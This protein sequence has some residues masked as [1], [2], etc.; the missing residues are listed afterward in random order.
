MVT[1]AIDV[2]LNET[3]KFPPSP[4]FIAQANVKGAA[5]YDKLWE[6]TAPDLHCRESPAFG[7][8]AAN[9]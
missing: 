9:S 1:G 2:V 5:E 4:E 3:R 7:L 8:S 6:R